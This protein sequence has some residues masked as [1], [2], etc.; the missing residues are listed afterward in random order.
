M[1][2]LFIEK[3]KVRFYFSRVNGVCVDIVSVYRYNEGGD[4]MK[5]NEIIILIISKTG[6]LLLC[7]KG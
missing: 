5:I 4:N 2:A 3:N 1:F 7:V 6:N